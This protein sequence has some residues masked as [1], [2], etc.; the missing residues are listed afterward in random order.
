MHPISHFTHRV[1]EPDLSLTEDFTGHD[2]RVESFPSIGIFRDVGNR[3][4]AAGIGLPP[5]AKER[6]WLDGRRPPEPLDNSG[7]RS[8]ASHG[9]AKTSLQ[10]VHTELAAAHDHCNLVKHTGARTNL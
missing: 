6:R 8:R 10:I 7:A 3:S 4:R 2:D 9:A 5:C 1:L